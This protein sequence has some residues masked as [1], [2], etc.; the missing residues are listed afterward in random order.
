MQR[1]DQLGKS[2]KSSKPH[3]P[4]F[5]IPRNEAKKVIMSTPKT[6]KVLPPARIEMVKQFQVSDEDGRTMPGTNMLLLTQK[7]RTFIFRNDP[8]Y[9]TLKMPP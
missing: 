9:A 8:Y 2:N 4:W 6:G 5:R 3:I 7:V 1:A